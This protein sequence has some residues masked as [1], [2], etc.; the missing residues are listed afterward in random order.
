[1]VFHQKEIFFPPRFDKKSFHERPWGN[2][3]AVEPPVRDNPKCQAQVLTYESLDHVE[4]KFCMVRI[5]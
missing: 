4:S 1:M 3:N 2:A 5:W